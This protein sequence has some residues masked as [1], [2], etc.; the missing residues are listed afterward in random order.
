V[1]A[2]WEPIQTAGDRQTL[3]VALEAMKSR[4]RNANPLWIQYTLGTFISKEEFLRKAKANFKDGK[5]PANFSPKDAKVEGA[6]ELAVKG[7]KYRS[8]DSSPIIQPDGASAPVAEPAISIFDGRQVVSFNHVL[9]P[10]G[11]RPIYTISRVRSNALS[12]ETPWSVLGESTLLNLL[13]NWKK[14]PSKYRSASVTRENS[15]SGNPLLKIRTQHE[16]GWVNQAWLREDLGYC[17]ERFEM[18]WQNGKPNFHAEAT[19]YKDAE[20]LP[21]PMAGKCAL[22]TDDGAKVKEL[23]FKIVKVVRNAEEIPDSLFTVP[24]PTNAEIFDADLK[25]NVRD[26]DRVQ[27]YLDQ[28]SAATLAPSPWKRFRWPITVAVAASVV[29]LLV[30]INRRRDLREE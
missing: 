14:G 10:Y 26:P 16:N 29:G 25:I 2:A 23:T 27:A 22:F 7:L 24:V 9:S 21:T 1:H 18:F 20:G 12:F 15:P 6:A 8:S 11:R 17:I 5:P 4:E 19:E 28:I 3:E 30:W 13:S